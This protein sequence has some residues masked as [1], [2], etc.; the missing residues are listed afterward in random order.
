MV[1][2]YA[3]TEQKIDAILTVYSILTYIGRYI[4]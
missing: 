1:N 3:D 4:V 2:N